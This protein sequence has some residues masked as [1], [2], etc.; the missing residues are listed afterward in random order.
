MSL[1]DKIEKMTD[2]ED[3]IKGVINRTLDIDGDFD[4]IYIDINSVVSIAFRA[5]NIA[6]D[7]I[8]DAVFGAFE[9]LMT[10]FAPKNTEIYLLFST[11][12]SK[13]HTNIYPDWCK[14]RYERVNL[15]KSDVVKQLIFAM[16]K[17]SEKNKLVRVINTKEFHPALII[18][19]LEQGVKTNF[20]ISSKDT[21][22][23]GLDIDH[24]VLFTGVRYI[25]Y[26][27]DIS[28]FTDKHSDN[29]V[30]RKFVKFYHALCRDDRN[31][32]PGVGNKTGPGRALKYIKDYKLELETGLDHPHKEWVDKY[33]KLYDVGEMLIDADKEKLNKIIS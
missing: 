27:N 11:Q 12:N 8:A 16:K 32:F 33:S 21:V 7:K 15:S 22:F 18:K 1:D 17:F 3:V 10:K 13:Y 14:S 6:S 20:I 2:F 4:R 26:G 30:P 23:Y 31:E 28:I 9:R 29:E 24:G 25:D 5:E 19:Y